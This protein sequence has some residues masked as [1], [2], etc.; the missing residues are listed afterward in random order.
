LD[1]AN[2]LTYT[3]QDPM[4]SLFAVDSNGVFKIIANKL[5]NDPPSVNNAYLV[6]V[7]MSDADGNKN[8][9]SVIVQLSELN[10]KMKCPKISDS[11]ICNFAINQSGFD[12]S[13][14]KFKT[15]IS[16]L[17]KFNFFFFRHY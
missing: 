8:F 17:S 1:P 7:I 16:Y 2:K 5:T 9:V 4:S 15:K 3:V 12:P 13:L 14:S 6:N 11:A 10:T